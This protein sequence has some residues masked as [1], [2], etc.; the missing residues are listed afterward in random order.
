M[1]IWWK[2]N[3]LHNKYLRLRLKL[4]NRNWNL[5]YLLC[6]N[7]IIDVIRC[8]SFIHNDVSSTCLLLRMAIVAWYL[9]HFH[10]LL[11]ILIFT[12]MTR[13]SASP[14]SSDT[15]LP[16]PAVKNRA[17]LDKLSKPKLV[18][19]AVELG[20]T[21]SDLRHALLDPNTGLVPI[22]QR[23]AAQLESQLAISQ[24]VNKTLLSHLGRVEK[25]ANENSQYARRET[26]EIHGIPESFGDGAPW[27]RKSLICWM[28][29]LALLQMTPLVEWKRQISH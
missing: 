24:S 3:L 16:L 23:Q 9:L 20:S 5:K 15:G 14:Q 13:N 27:K 29:L 17:D 21:L 8:N 26:L 22:L 25:T 11:Y 19:Y 2:N 12:S 7:T 6:L 1:I 4:R 28:T 18:D 10:D